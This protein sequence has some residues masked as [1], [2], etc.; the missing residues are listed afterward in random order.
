MLPCFGA[1]ENELAWMIVIP[2]C[3]RDRDIA[4]L[5]MSEHDGP[6]DLE[7]AAQ[8]AHIVRPSIDGPLLRRGRVTPPRAAHVREHQLG[9]IGERCKLVF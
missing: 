3:I 4:T 8:R 6:L 1:I 2:R 5:G 9:D 7:R